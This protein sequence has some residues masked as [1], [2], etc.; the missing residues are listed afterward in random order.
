MNLPEPLIEIQLP[1]TERGIKRY[2]K[3]LNAAAKIFTEQGY[4][5]ANIN[6]IVKI[7]GGSLGTV[8]KYFGNKLGLFEAFFKHTTQEVFSQ[9][10]AEDFWSDD[11]TASL[12]RF[13]QALQKLMLMPDALVIYKLVL[14]DNSGDRAEIQRIFLE[15]GPNIINSYLSNFLQEQI[16]KG[17]IRQINPKIASYQFVDMLKGPIYFHALFGAEIDQQTCKETLEQAIEVFVKGVS[18]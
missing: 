6:E 1:S 2:K 12:T 17:N 4:D 13:A 14:T 16:D 5:N 7:S 11:L 15:N 9:F 18:N 8:Y 3:I 10:Y